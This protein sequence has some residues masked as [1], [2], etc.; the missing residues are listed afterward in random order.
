MHK[1]FGYRKCSKE[2]LPWTNQLPHKLADLRVLATFSVAFMCV[3]LFDIVGPLFV[4]MIP[5]L[6]YE[7]FR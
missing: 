6:S 2:K 1:P 3:T 4:A 7:V 5:I